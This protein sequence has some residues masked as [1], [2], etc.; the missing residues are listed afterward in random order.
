M[1]LLLDLDLVL[2]VGLERSHVRQQVRAR[3][4]RLIA[5]LLELHDIVRRILYL[6][7]KVNFLAENGLVLSLEL[8]NFLHKNINVRHVLNSHL[9][10]VGDVE[11]LFATHPF[12]HRNVGGLLCTHPFQSAVALLRPLQLR[13]QH[14][15]V[16]LQ[17]LVDFALSLNF[18]FDSAQVF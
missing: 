18:C 7:L 14:R 11:R 17:T 13:L 10:K 3:L 5:L 8:G 2:V 4:I 9:F 12:E 1:L 16:R 6:L 15:Y